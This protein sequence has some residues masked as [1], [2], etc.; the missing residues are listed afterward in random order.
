MKPLLRLLRK[1]RDA[2]KEAAL[3]KLS[4]AQ[5]QLSQ[6]M[7]AVTAT[8]QGFLQAQQWR[9]ELVR[10]NGAGLGR[11]WRHTMLPSCQVLLEMRASQVT[12]AISRVEECQ[13]WVAQ[14]RAALT[15]CEKALLRTD[16]LQSILKGQ[17]RDAERLA[18]Q[19]QDD[20]LA[21]AHG[22]MATA[23]SNPAAQEQPLWT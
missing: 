20:D 21:I 6:A 15:A 5:S 10:R 23:P 8:H 9:E 18:E 2:R 12:E 19:S 11:D 16:E 14:A 3:A 7:A 13:Q 4:S 22:G 1:T 17:A